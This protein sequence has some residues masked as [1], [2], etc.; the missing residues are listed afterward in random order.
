VALKRLGLAVVATPATGTAVAAD[1]NDPNAVNSIF[2]G[3]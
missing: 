2:A 1:H 3:R